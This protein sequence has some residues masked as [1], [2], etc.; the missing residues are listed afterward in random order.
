LRKFRPLA[1]ALIVLIICLNFSGIT[2][3]H[4]MRNVQASGAADLLR[5]SSAPDQPDANLQKLLEQSV[6]GL[7]GD[8]ALAVKKLDTGQMAMIRGNDRFVAASLYKLDVLLAVASLHAQGKLKYDDT[9]TT[10]L[11]DDAEDYGN[12]DPGIDP[13]T[14]LT[15]Q[16]AAELMIDESNNT[17]ASMLLRAVGGQNIINSTLQDYGLS[18][19]ILDPNNDN[20][21]SSGDVMRFFEM[22]YSARLIDADESEWM[23]DILLRQELNFLIPNNLPNDVPVAH[24]TGNLLNLMHDAGI[25]YA[26]SGPFAIVVLAQN[27]DTE[28]TARAQIP[29]IAQ[30]VYD[31]FNQSDYQPQRTFPETGY[32]VS[33]QFLKFWNTWGGLR[34]FGYPLTG[35]VI[36]SGMQVQYFER[37]RFEWHY[38]DA[39][40]PVQLTLLGS[41]VV[42]AHGYPTAAVAPNNADDTQ[43]F[44]ATGHNVSK[45]FLTYWRNHGG[46]LVFGY[47]I[48][49][50]FEEVSPSNGRKY[51]VQYFE[52]ARFELHDEGSDDSYVLLGSLGNEELQLRHQSHQQNTMDSLFEQVT[53]IGSI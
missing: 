24:K 27:L 4:T 46:L 40:N 44:A 50:R 34:Q 36:E 5:W 47:P 20:L 12:G 49:E 15:V 7:P 31:Y 14:V 2:S 6:A 9:I 11:D 51:V 30:A 35:V 38:S 45:S 41:Q 43:F 3:A 29:T 13:G 25:V 32:T 10:I 1:S 17:A 8:W 28:D 42:T 22:L 18:R 16:R 37:A 19:T 53:Q 33:G 39:N 21:T 26:P 48:T 52:R 23:L